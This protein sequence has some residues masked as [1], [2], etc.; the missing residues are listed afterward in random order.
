VSSL[1]GNEPPEQSGQNGCGFPALS[2]YALPAQVH[3][4]SE[5][6][7]V[8]GAPAQACGGAVC[9]WRELATGGSSLESSSSHSSVVG[10]RSCRSFAQYTDAT[11]GERGR[12]G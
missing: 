12:N 5:A 2:L 1:P 6:A 10:C 8:P 4:R 7:R 11:R 3:T 9:G